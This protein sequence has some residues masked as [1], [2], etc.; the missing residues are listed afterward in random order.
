MQCK[1]E[2]LDYLIKIELGEHKEQ[3]NRKEELEDG[4]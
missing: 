2:I 3:E 1:Q 4:P